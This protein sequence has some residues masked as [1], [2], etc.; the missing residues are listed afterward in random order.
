MAAEKTRPDVSADAVRELYAD[1]LDMD[2]SGASS[3]DVVQMLDD[4]FTKNGFPTV[5]YRR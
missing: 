4:W 1:Y 2:E 3:N 5:I